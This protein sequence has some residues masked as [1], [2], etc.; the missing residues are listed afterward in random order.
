MSGAAVRRTVVVAVSALVVTTAAPVHAVGATSQ[1]GPVPAPTGLELV[2]VADAALSADG[3]LVVYAARA[4][5]GDE[6]PRWGLVVAD[7]SSGE[8]SRL[9]VEVDGPIGD[10]DVS[11]DASR[12]VFQAG[13][14]EW[15][16]DWAPAQVHVHDRATGVTTLVSTTGSAPGVG[17][18]TQPEIS[19]DGEVVAFTTA[20]RNLLGLPTG[21][22]QV[23]GVVATQVGSGELEVLA[24]RQGDAHGPSLSGDGQLVAYSTDEPGIPGDEVSDRRDTHVVVHDRRGGE[25]QLVTREGTGT[26][27]DLSADGS[28]V[29]WT[30]VDGTTPSRVPVFGTWATDLA[31][32]TTTRVDV[33][34]QGEPLH[35]LAAD[36]VVSADGRYVLFG[37][38]AR[39]GPSLQALHLHD[40]STGTTKIVPVSSTPV[41]PPLQAVDVSADGGVVLHARGWPGQRSYWV[42]EV[43]ELLPVPPGSPAP[44]PPQPVNVAPPVLE[45]ISTG[46]S[47]GFRLARAGE[48]ESPVPLFRT[49][50]WLR[51]G[52]PVTDSVGVTYVVGPDDI[53]HVI[54]L[55]EVVTAPRMGGMEVES[56]GV[57]PRKVASALRVRVQR[58]K[59]R[60]G[61]VVVRVRL[62]HEWGVRPQGRVVVRWGRQVRRLAVT[63]DG[64]A[65][66]RLL[67]GAPGRRT[68][69]VV[70]R[71]TGLVKAAQAVRKT[72]RVKSRPRR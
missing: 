45:R 47:Y 59:G 46:G 40:L 23:R 57:V 49:Y 16:P 35:G 56:V 52:Q 37:G 50:Q 27:A 60:A 17:P 64:R 33:D 1:E 9:D 13:A 31:T 53:G 38:L 41:E 36:A 62:G 44:Q 68:L 70:H 20:A 14:S 72:I 2:E 51:D 61:R 58:P 24:G 43:T 8:A 66:V 34:A 39:S 71:G 55:R 25:L 29:V 32:G 7:R 28:T 26:G 30:R 21:S 3:S 12:I 69:K 5:A 11:D 15:E 10:V 65:N 18:S 63:D 48:W 67:A 22:G 6:A 42:Q 54:S 19:G 4:R